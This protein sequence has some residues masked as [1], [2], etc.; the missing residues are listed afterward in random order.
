[1]SLKPCLDCGRPRTPGRCPACQAKR[2]SQRGTTT[3]RGYGTDHQ[4]RSAALRELQRA[5]CLC[6]QAIDYT[7]RGPH[8]RSFTAHHLTRDKRGPMDAAHRVCNE[9]AGQPG[10]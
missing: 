3:D 8:P 10:R 2:D 5:C 6:G 1:M 7:L 4:R 9:R